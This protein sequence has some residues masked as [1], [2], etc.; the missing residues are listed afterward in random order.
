MKKK[1][2]SN[3]S[4]SCAEW[5]LFVYPIYL[6]TLFIF[7]YLIYVH[8]YCIYTYLLYALIFC[9]YINEASKSES[10]SEIIKIKYEKKAL[11]MKKEH[12]KMICV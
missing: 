2:V 11:K 3:T 9:T 7:V 1:E 5:K 10:Q 6:Y 4:N 8:L 12:D